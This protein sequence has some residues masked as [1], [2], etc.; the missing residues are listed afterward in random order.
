MESRG[1]VAYKLPFRLKDKQFPE[2][3]RLIV[4]TEFIFVSSESLPGL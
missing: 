1:F 2:K 4:R 3:G